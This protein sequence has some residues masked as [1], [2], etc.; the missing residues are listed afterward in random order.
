MNIA[1]TLHNRVPP[2]AVAYCAGLFNDLNATLKVTRP[3]RTKH[4]DF[5]ADAQGQCVITVNESL[6][7]YAFLITYI[8]EV[9]HLAV[10]RRLV[11]ASRRRHIRPHGTEWQAAFRS[12]MAPLLNESVFP[13]AILIQLQGYMIKPAASSGTHIGLTQALREYDAPPGGHSLLVD[14]AEG[15]T[16][17]FQKKQYVRG[18]KRR[19]RIV[20]T[21]KDTGN[22]VLIWAHVWVETV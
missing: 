17:A 16:F 7:P 14:L 20:C 9:A 4:G 12:L 3:R 19:T 5:R 8:H 1:S 6:N 15:Q 2:A 21:E 10:Y 18:M 13:P 22:R 11:Q